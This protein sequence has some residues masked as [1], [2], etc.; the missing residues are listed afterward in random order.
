MKGMMMDYPLTIPSV[1]DYAAKFHGEAEIVSRTVEGPIHRYGY[2]NSHHRIRQLCKALLAQGV[3]PG[4]RVAT[5]AWNGY[6]HFELYYAIAS[7]G[8][9]C[10]TLNPRL[11]PEQLIYIINHAED[12]L[13]FFDL[14]FTPLIDG[15]ADKLPT[16]ERFVAMTDA[17]HMPESKV[18]LACYEDLLG[19]QDADFA[20][21]D[22]DEN[23]ASG[24]CYT[25]GTT[26]NPKGVVYSHRSTVLHA[27]AGNMRD[28]LGLCSHSVLLPVVPMFHVNAWGAPYGCA[29]AGAKLVL[30][31]AGMDGASIHELI[32]S[33]EATCIS[34][35]PTIWL[36]LLDFLKTNNKRIDSVE[37]VVIGG[38][39]APRSMI[40]TFQNDY[41][42]RVLHAWGMTETSPLGTVGTFRKAEESLSDEEKI[43]LQLKQGRGIFGVELRIVGDDG[44]ELPWDGKAF[45]E[46]EVRGPWIASGY[47][48]GEGGEPLDG[49]WFRTGDVSTIDSRGYMQITDRA[50]D[51]IKSGGEWISSIELEN[52]AVSHEGIA[53]AAVIGM[54]HKKWDERPLLVVVPVDKSNPPSKESVLEHLTGRIAKWWMPDDVQ[55]VDELPH[56]A[57]GKISK[58]TLRE[59]FADYS[60]PS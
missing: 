5:L 50:K 8:A 4:D 6:R 49:G 28:T 25:S 48:K 59:Q 54:A 46:L 19:V 9:V 39:A 20:W 21:P 29:M 17:S 53:E 36:M 18:D 56:T 37:Q 16:V 43:Q 38:S 60:W 24:L 34:G 11:F 22:I 7:I 40:E 23:A 41:D 33:E 32:D 10:H 45:G 52:E 2:A 13:V 31:G 57:T 1:I 3:K 55:V 44:K 51:V 58:K 42:T 27:M 30:P 26:G 12:K 14:T 35:V 15:L 47:F